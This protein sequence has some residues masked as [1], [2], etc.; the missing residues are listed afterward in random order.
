[1]D[2]IN[3]N[4]LLHADSL[5]SSEK[6]TLRDFLPSAPHS[7]KN[8]ASHSGNPLRHQLLDSVGITINPRVI[9]EA[10]MKMSHLLG[11]SEPS[12]TLF[13]S[14]QPVSGSPAHLAALLPYFTQLKN[15]IEK[16]LE[17]TTSRLMSLNPS[18]RE[19]VAYYLDRLA[20]HSSPPSSLNGNIDGAGGLRRWVEGPRSPAQNLALQ[21]YF[22]EIALLTLGQS[23]LLKVWSDRGH[24]TWTRADL[25]DL[26]WALNTSI[27]KFI[28][29]DRENWHVARQNIYSWY[30]PSEDIQNQIW[31]IT[32]TWR[33]QNEGPGFLPWL[34]SPA[35]AY[36]CENSAPQG[37]DSRFYQAIWKH[38]PEFG[39]N[40]VQMPSPI[41][42]NWVFFSPTLR[43]G[44]LTQTTP[45]TVSWIGAE[46]SA[47]NLMTAE[48]MEL[49]IKPG[50]PPLWGIGTGLDAHASDQLS[51]GTGYSNPKPSLISRI[52]EMEACDVAFVLEERSTRLSGKNAE[53]HRL[54]ELLEGLP[55]FKKLRSAGTTLGDLQACVSLSKLRPGG[56]LWW[57]REE[58]LTQSDGSEM[59]NFMLE[60]AKLCCEWDFSQLEHS[61]PTTKPAFPRYLYLFA[62]E[63]GVE[64]RLTHRPTRIAAQGQIR[65]HVEI[66]FMLQEVFAAFHSSSERSESRGQWKLHLQKSPT[67][68]R[69][70]SER[71]PDPTCQKTLRNIERIRENSLPLASATTIRPAVEGSLS[72]DGLQ[73][74]HHWL[75]GLKDF[76]GIWIYSEQNSE[77]RRL[78]AIP[79]LESPSKDQPSG[80]YGPTFLMLVADEGW[81]APLAQYLESETVQMWLDH[82]A[83]R[84]GERWILSEQLVKCIPVPRSLLAQLGFDFGSETLSLPLDHSGNE[85]GIISRLLENPRDSTVKITSLSLNGQATLFTQ[86]SREIEKL[87]MGHGSFLSLITSN[88]TIRWSELLKM[89]P[90]AESVT[91]PLHPKIRILGNLPLHLAIGRFERVQTPSPGILLTTEA[92]FH[93]CLVS[94]HSLLLDMIWDQ[95]EGLTSPTWSELVTYLRLPRRIELAEATASDLLKIHGEQSRRMQE[96]SD[97]VSSCQLF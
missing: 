39:L 31:E 73:S 92:G 72:K 48:L 4:S 26:N 44:A 10:R 20:G 32:N 38:L 45:A 54:R 79:I 41:K 43:D 78:R 88:G 61:L 18:R 62:R 58:P 66:P 91:V 55:Y 94:D 6:E 19:A 96:L 70:W 36:R 67:P 86:A 25:R 93:L 69:E 46:T 56:L 95:L 63:T 17:N 47:F 27:K 5:P 40:P 85:S 12:P 33:I 8:E 34:F 84:K 35:R 13:S 16:E 2:Q 15:Q 23:L 24:R 74:P 49:W 97:L 59:L 11:S 81:L 1:M 64:A 87:R 50:T 89:L 22:E 9:E 82:F 3:L 60:R 76:K 30:K 71:W 65:S 37:Y 68:Q 83:E 28:P 77:T 14:I 53:A 90:A 7:E 52:A 80:N 75:E 57:A 51:L 42:R 21:I 29:H